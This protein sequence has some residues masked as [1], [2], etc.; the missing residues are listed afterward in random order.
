MA[1]PPRQMLPEATPTPVEDSFTF[2]DD[3]SLFVC[4]Y[5]GCLLGGC[6][7]VRTRKQISTFGG[8]L[9]SCISLKASS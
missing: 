9:L 4:L 1:P 7:R 6:I 2:I 8:T 3:R 5:N